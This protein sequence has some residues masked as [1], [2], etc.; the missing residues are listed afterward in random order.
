M[1][2]WVYETKDLEVIKDMCYVQTLYTHL[3]I[4]N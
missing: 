4:E 1:Q 2:V 3:S